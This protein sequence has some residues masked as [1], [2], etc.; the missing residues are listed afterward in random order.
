[1]IHDTYSIQQSWKINFQRI[2]NWQSQK[3]SKTIS[4]LRYFNYFVA[5]HFLVSSLQFF[6]W[7]YAHLT[8]FS[9]HMTP[10]SW[11]V[12]W[13]DWL[14]HFAGSFFD[15]NEFNQWNTNNVCSG[16]AEFAAEWNIAKLCL[17]MIFVVPNKS[18][19]WRAKQNI[20]LKG[21]S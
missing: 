1:M 8:P 15:R 5:L 21:V 10:W 4:S 13:F 3:K 18:C 17:T 2:W 16:G 20:S 11:D 9:I 12:T 14:F 6:Y 7:F 19:Y